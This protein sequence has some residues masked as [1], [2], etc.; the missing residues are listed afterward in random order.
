MMKFRLRDLAV[1]ALLTLFG[2]IM[3]ISKMLMEFLPNIHLIAMFITLFT[4]LF[5]AKALIPIYIFVF[6]TGFYG[7]FALWWV[8]YLYV[9]TVLWAVVM[10]L[11]KNMKRTTATIVYIIVTGLHGMFYGILYAPFQAFAFGLDFRGMVAWVI[12]GLPFD[13][14]QCIGNTISATLVMPLV[15]PL[16]R[17]ID[18]YI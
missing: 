8:P 11:P 4:V 17:E 7:G 9:W 1:L 15:I 3:F 5:R 6:L 10:I 14:V 12:S 2:V 18:K 13:L 16:K